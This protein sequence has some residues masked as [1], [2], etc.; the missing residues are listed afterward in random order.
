MSFGQ[1]NSSLELDDILSK[2]SEYQILAFYL[3]ITKVPCIINSPLRNDN[4]ASF[5]LYSIDNKIYYTDLATKDKGNLFQLLSKFWCLNFQEVLN[6]V[7]KDLN[8]ISSISPNKLHNYNSAINMK[9]QITNINTSNSNLQCVVRDWKD[10]DIQYWESYGVTLEWLKR[11]DIYPISHKIIIKDGK[12]HRFPADKHA[13]AYVERKEGKITLKIYQPF[14]T[15]GFKWS[16]KHDR[17]VISF[18]TKIP[19]TGNLLIVC[20]SLKDA[21]CI[22]NNTHIPCIAIQGEGY[23]ISNRVIKELNERF[24]KV[25]ISFDGDSPGINNA[26]SLSELT[27]WKYINTPLITENNKTAKDWSDIYHYFGKERFLKEFT[28]L[29]L[30]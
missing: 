7:S 27:N 21:L 22:M 23:S 16:N 20:S 3:H 24:N 26:K 8:N 17:S 29:I 6:R 18:W 15:K 1:G 25:I 13:Y 9:G 30:Q 19:K 12:T 2:V 28:N 4:K 11:A 10:Y 5:G 14:N